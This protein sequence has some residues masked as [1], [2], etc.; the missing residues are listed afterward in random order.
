MLCAGS[1]REKNA[2]NMLLWCLL[3]S[4]GGAFG[5]W[6]I[7]YALAYGGDD[8]SLGKTFVGNSGFFLSLSG[9][10]DLAFWC[11]SW[12]LFLTSCACLFS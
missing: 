5:F 7:G 6:S 4:A 9:D 3:D 2:K 8:A 1:I 11:A 10:I 12:C